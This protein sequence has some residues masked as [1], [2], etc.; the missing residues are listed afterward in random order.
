MPRSPRL[1]SRTTAAVQIIG[2]VAAAGMLAA[3]SRVRNRAYGS[4][5][6]LWRD[7]LDRSPAN[8]RAFDN[9]SVLALRAGREAGML[10]LYDHY[11]AAAT[12][13]RAQ[14][15]LALALSRRGDDAAAE[16]ARARA[17]AGI[18]EAVRQHDNE[19]DA[20]FHLGNL[21]RGSDSAAAERAYRR[22][23]AAD[24]RH[25]DAL[26]NLGPLVA[27]RDR[28]EARALY[29]QALAI[30]P[31]HADAWNNLGVL[32]MREGDRAGAARCF[33]EALAARPTLGSA[34][35]NL[36]R[37]EASPVRTEP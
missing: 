28:V 25:V 16:M 11:P 26:A 13:F 37:I 6:G 36:S 27:Q 29:E 30:D 20:W 4:A 12:D 18:E 2:V 5:E 31:S 19:A 21:L 22:A 1:A 24:A 7:T 32:L 34:R 10:N 17:I 3:G 14:A 15:R 9:A 8:V 33:R 35:V 23:A